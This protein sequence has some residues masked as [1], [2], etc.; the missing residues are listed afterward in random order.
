MKNLLKIYHEWYSSL[1]IIKNHAEE[2]KVVYDK[3]ALNKLIDDA[4]R[5][6]E[7]LMLYENTIT[8]DKQGK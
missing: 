4:A 8:K 3:G 5:E 1:L 7:C 2:L 6:C